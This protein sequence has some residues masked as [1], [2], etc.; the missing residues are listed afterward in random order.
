M[1]PYKCPVCGGR[2]LVPQNFYYDSE[3][4]V[5]GTEMCL[6][7]EGTGVIF[8]NGVNIFSFPKGIRDNVE[9]NKDD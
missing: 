2:G 8:F 9:E 5:L 3:R 4:P 7:C 1:Q 6:T